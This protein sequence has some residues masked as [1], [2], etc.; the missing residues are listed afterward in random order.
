MKKVVRA[1]V[2]AGVIGSGFLALPRVFSLMGALAGT[3]G[4]TFVV[5]L[6][7]RSRDATAR[8]ERS[9]DR[10]MQA[11]CCRMPSAPAQSAGASL[12]V[13]TMLLSNLCASLW[14]ACAQGFMTVFTIMHGLVRPSTNPATGS[15]NMRTYASMVGLHASSW[16]LTEGYSW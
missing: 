13:P 11:L 4:L 6:V 8:C 14:P 3:L 1:L 2:P 10:A 7:L 9:Q 16:G 5:R 15:L 12:F